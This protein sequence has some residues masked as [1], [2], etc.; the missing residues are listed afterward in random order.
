MGQVAAKA[1][2]GPL[3]GVDYPDT[4]RARNRTLSHNPVQAPTPWLPARAVFRDQ[5]RQ[6]V[7]THLPPYGSLWTVNVKL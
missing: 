3:P 5:C 4:R 6:E 2:T 1:F 7:T